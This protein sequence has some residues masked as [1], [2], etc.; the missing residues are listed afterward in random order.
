[1]QV[2]PLASL[3][4]VRIHAAMNCGVGCRS[5]SDTVVLLGL[6]HGPEAAAPI[7]PL[8]CELPYA[9][10]TVLKRKKRKEK[11]ADPTALPLLCHWLERQIGANNLETKQHN[12]VLTIFSLKCILDIQMKF[13]SRQ[14]SI[15]SSTK[16]TYLLEIIIITV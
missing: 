12:Y 16:K 5:S 9:T 13:I 4:G 7:W 2:W 11:K 3:S 15:C 8:P 1:M 14:L 6:W 10:G